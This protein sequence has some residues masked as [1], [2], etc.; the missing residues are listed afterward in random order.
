MSENSVKMDDKL[1]NGWIKMDD[2]RGRINYYS[3]TPRVQI[4]SK[5]ALLQYQSKGKF[6]EI[7]AETLEFGRRRKRKS[8]V[9]DSE[10]PVCQSPS[11]EYPETSLTQI[12]TSAEASSSSQL[13]PSFDETFSIPLLGERADIS[14]LKF[15]V[16]TKD[17]FI[18]QVGEVTESPS[19][20]SFRA[21]VESSFIHKTGAVADSS[22]TPNDGAVSECSSIAKVGVGVVCS[23]KEPLH[24]F[25]SSFIIFFIPY[26]RLKQVQDVLSC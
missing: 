10:V 22:F 16:N 2:E 15:G 7:D 5:T 4:H 9:E 6:R 21:D 14:S 23:S 25:N 19:T 1:P 17:F 13:G 3:P 24:L 12:G 8:N 11:S 20:P 18:E 26:L